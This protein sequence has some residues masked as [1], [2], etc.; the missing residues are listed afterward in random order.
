MFAEIFDVVGII[1]GFDGI[2]GEWIQ[3]ESFGKLAWS[4]YSEIKKN[5]SVFVFD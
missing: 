3:N 5:D 4:V 1:A 2:V